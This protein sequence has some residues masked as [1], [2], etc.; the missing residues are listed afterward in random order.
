M[1]ADGRSP[2]RNGSNGITVSASTFNQIGTAG[3]ESS[4]DNVIS[5][6]GAN[7]IA[8]LNGSNDNRVFGNYIGTSKTSFTA[9]G[10]GTPGR[11][12]AAS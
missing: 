10:N 11:A 12:D 3:L 2:L 5:G 6:N 9:Q 7:G 8:L 4:P 1:T